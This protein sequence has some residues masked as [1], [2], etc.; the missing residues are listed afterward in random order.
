M[1]DVDLGD[2][3]TAQGLL[4]DQNEDGWIDTVRARLVLRQDAS[5]AEQLAAINIAARLG[6]ET[7]SLALPIAVVE[8]EVM[9][10]P[11]HSHPIFI[12]S[13]GH[14]AHDLDPDDV[15]T[16]PLGPGEGVLQLLPATASMPQGLMV[17][18]GDAAGVTAAA[19]LLSSRIPYVWHTGAG[20][21]TLHDVAGSLRDWLAAA[22]GADCTLRITAAYVDA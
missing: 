22:G 3:Y 2:L 10:W 5:L 4:A 9:P 11:P 7:M 18:G 17:V 14:A 16:P 20:L 8:H 12:A 13:G 1:C 21:P 15:R 6:F 19:S